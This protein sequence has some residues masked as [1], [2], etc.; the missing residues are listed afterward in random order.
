M[1]LKMQVVVFC[2]IVGYQ[3]FRGPS[4]LH[5]QGEVNGTGKDGVYIGLKMETAMSSETLVYIGIL[6]QHY[7]ASQPRRP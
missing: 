1:T 3:H 5:L 4:C 7:M 6:P 2:V